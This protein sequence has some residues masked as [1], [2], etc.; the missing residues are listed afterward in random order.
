M[1]E[2]TNVAPTIVRISIRTLSAVRK[3]KC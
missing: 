3:K 2:V 1:V